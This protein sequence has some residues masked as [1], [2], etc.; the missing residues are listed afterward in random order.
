MKSQPFKIIPKIIDSSVLD[1]IYS[2]MRKTNFT[3][4]DFI[5]KCQLQNLLKK[6]R[7]RIIPHTMEELS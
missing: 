3:S 4:N 5:F 7:M 2:L 6:I 1:E